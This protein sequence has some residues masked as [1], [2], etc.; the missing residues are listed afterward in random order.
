MNVIFCL[1]GFSDFRNSVSSFSSFSSFSNFSPGDRKAGDYRKTGKGWI[2]LFL[3]WGGLFS[4]CSGGGG[5]VT[6]SFAAEESAVDET[7]TDDKL[8]RT[9]V[10]LLMVS[11]TPPYIDEDNNRGAELDLV[12]EALALE[13]YRVVPRFVPNKRRNIEYSSGRYDGALTVSLNDQLDGCYSDSYLAYQTVAISLRSRKFSIRKIDDL[14][15]KR[16]VAF[17]TASVILGPEFT[18]FARENRKYREVA[19]RRDLLLLLLRGHAD[20]VVGEINIANWMLKHG[21]YPDLVDVTQSLRVHRIFHP[22]VKYAVFT[23]PA[24]CQAFNRGIETL[25]R[26]GDYDETLRAYGILGY[27]LDVLINGG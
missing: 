2:A 16:V 13:G 8:A 23:D 3:F 7:G 21:D 6:R 27:E 1:F 11:A 15:G 5:P 25:Q 22:S 17:Q 10:S 24:L 26:S 12:R 18:S 20:V 19:K 9:A 4:F 14:E